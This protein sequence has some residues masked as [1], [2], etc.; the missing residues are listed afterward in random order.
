MSGSISWRR[1][2]GAVGCLAVAALGSVVSAL[3][4][5]ALVL[6]V[7]AGVI[8]A[9]RIAAT[10]RRRRGEPTPLEALEMETG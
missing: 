4:I 6:G 8:A 5:A 10:R 3:V 7:L 9:E 1:L 2:G